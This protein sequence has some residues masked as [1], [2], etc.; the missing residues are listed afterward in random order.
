M[1]THNTG[2]E[3]D[4][5]RP[6]QPV[7]KEI[8]GE[9]IYLSKLSGESTE[10]SGGGV[11]IPIP[12]DQLYRF[13]AKIHLGTDEWTSDYSKALK[14]QFPV[15]F[16]RRNVNKSVELRF[17]VKGPDGVETASKESVYAIREF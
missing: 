12:D 5:V 6:M 9:I 3:S 10:V 7:F 13:S 14:A 17:H 15:D 11:I 16:L 4:I 8:K 2:K 1:S